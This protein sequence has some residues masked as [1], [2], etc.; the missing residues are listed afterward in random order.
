[1][2]LFIITSVIHINQSIGW[3]YTNIRSSYSDLER[4]EQ[5]Y[6]SIESIRERCPTAKIALI[7]ASILT[8]EEI[9]SFKLKVD[10]F[11]DVSN[12][13]WVLEATES[14]KKGFGEC[15]QILHFLKIIP[16]LPFRR[17]FKL[18]GRYYLSPQFNESNYSLT[19]PTFKLYGTQVSTVLYS[20]PLVLLDE[21]KRILSQCNDFYSHSVYSLESLFYEEFHVKPEYIQ[22]L[23]VKGFIAVSRSVLID[24]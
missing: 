11:C 3:T 10:Y 8:Q 18:S 20:Y 15:R 1:M 16:D 21:Y 5:T 7:E 9:D 4:L 22:T 12:D 6:T 14:I 2:D 13:K 19:Y 17:I 24:E 23:G